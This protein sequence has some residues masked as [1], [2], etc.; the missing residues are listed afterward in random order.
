MP[1]FPYKEFRPHQKK[2]YDAVLETLR[3]KTPLLI[4]A[5]TGIGKTAAVVGAVVDY[6]LD[7]NTPI[8]Y[9]VRTRAE[10]DPPVRE[11]NR[12]VESGID[13]EYAV[14]K[15]R[16]DMC[17]YTS[18]KKLSYQEFLAECSLLKATSRCEYYPI[19]NIKTILKN[20]NT[21]VKYLCTTKS[22]PY[23]YAKSR[24][25]DV[26][27]V[28]STYYYIF[29]KESSSVEGKV[30]VVDE[31]HSLFNAVV[32]LHSLEVSELELRSAYR[33]AKKY[34]YLEEA[35]KIYRLYNYIKK[36]SGVVDFGDLLSEIADVDLEQAVREIIAKKVESL[37]APYTP[38]IL[39]KELKTAL[40]S[41]VRYFAELRQT[42]VGKVLTISPIDPTSII[43][44]RLQDAYVVIF[45][46]GTLSMDL[47]TEVL[48]LENY[49]T[50]EVSFNSYVPRENYLVIVD[51]GV[52]TRY[53][54]RSE[55]TYFNIAKRLA[56]LINLSP[57]GVLA[58]FPSYE[59]MK[60]V[61][62]FLKVSIPHWYEGFEEIDL[63]EL[64]DKFFIGAVARGKYTEGVE[65]V[66]EGRNLLSSVAVVGIPYPE[67]TPYLEKRVEYLR[68]RL[69]ERAWDAVYLYEAIVAIRQAVGRLFRS[70]QDRG[71]LVFLD[72]R[73]AE[74]HIWKSL[75]DILQHVIV[76]K[77]LG[78]AVGEVE[79]FFTSESKVSRWQ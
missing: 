1:V 50:V 48:D 6:M 56:T 68:P 79:N 75:E 18:L 21:Y 70:P 58:V 32:H 34:G 23:E 14:I 67:P 29:G 10:L 55:D 30:V 42:E 62:K 45:M 72:W 57:G 52:T 65:Y 9:V 64:P 78:E 22:C 2:I 15:S 51:V 41:R 27:F 7:T 36:A 24:I 61:K 13:I 60:G 3:Q 38:L 49:R 69:R 63:T 71:V 59:V 17:C 53:N 8:H 4:N 40:R 11:L 73:Y 12:I 74:P 39:I 25:R 66:R 31:A 77:D 26:K 33:E 46:S 76:V 5:P 28:V 20:V 37:E 19:R 47:F 35:A 44:S 54:E 43:K 16:Q